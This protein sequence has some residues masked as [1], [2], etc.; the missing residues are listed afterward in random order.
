MNFDPPLFNVIEI[1]DT[2]EAMADSREAAS[3]GQGAFARQRAVPVT[4]R[5]M[6]G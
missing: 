2:G 5:G 6:A 3:H 1:T 4:R